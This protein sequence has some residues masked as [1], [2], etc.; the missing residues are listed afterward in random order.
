MA[1][2]TDA[3]VGGVIEVDASIPLAP[4]ISIANELVTELC[5]DSGYTETRL[6]LIETWL[7]AHFYG[8]RDQQVSREQAGSVSVAFQFKIALH[9][10]QT[11]QGQTAMLLDTAGNL[12]QLNKRIEDG[13]VPKIHMSWL[14]TDLDTEDDD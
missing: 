12:A 1:R 5:T 8:I 14:G 11:K 2:T 6:T 9:F 4:F 3:E 7:A 13:E 10:N